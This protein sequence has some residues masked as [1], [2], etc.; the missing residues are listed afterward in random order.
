MSYTNVDYKR[1]HNRLEKDSEESIPYQ[2]N[3][4]KRREIYG[5]KLLKK[6]LEDPEFYLED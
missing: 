2:K 1:K 6:A 3:Q 4:P 5:H